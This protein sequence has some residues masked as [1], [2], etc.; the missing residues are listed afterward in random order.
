MWH[1]WLVLQAD[2]KAAGRNLVNE[3][4]DLKMLARKTALM[5]ITGVLWIKAHMIVVK[6]LV[7]HA[8]ADVFVWGK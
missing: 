1:K 8:G 2:W 7:N 4:H 3:S 5:R 6:S